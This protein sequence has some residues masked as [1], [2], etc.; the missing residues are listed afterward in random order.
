MM[1]K[2]IL[3]LIMASILILSLYCVPVYASDA[4]DKKNSIR[5]SD[6]YEY[7]HDYVNYSITHNANIELMSYQQF[8]ELYEDQSYVSVYDYVTYLKEIIDGYS[9]VGVAHRS[10]SSSGSSGDNWYN[11]GTS[12]PERP[13]YGKY[14]FS[15]VRAGDIL[16]E[17]TGFMGLT[18]HIAIVEGWYYDA[19]YNVN[20]IRLIES[21]DVGVVRSYLDDDRFEKKEGQL[22]HVDATNA[23]VNSALYFCRMQ[24]GKPWVLQPFTKPTSIDHAQWQCSTL[25]WAAY[26]YAGVDV[27]EDGLSGTGVTPRDVRDAD[28]TTEYLNYKQKEE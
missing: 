26:N 9:N 20:Y 21:V 16:Y 5:N 10:G 11:I 17:G 23:Q 22:F 2:K 18:G 7:Y 28:T 27:E 25:V 12:L 13:S 15:D 19:T 14:D 1:S 8:L 4:C 3:A 24:L 6:M